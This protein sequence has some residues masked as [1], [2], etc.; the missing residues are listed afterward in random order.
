VN[1]V[2]HTR[3]CIHAS[4]LKISVSITCE[5]GVHAL[6]RPIIQGRVLASPK[7][8][9][10]HLVLARCVLKKSDAPKKFD[11]VFRTGCVRGTVCGEEQ[12]IQLVVTAHAE[13][14]PRGAH[15]G[16]V[17]LQQSRGGW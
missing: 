3:R 13:I 1:H 17:W 16:D 4:V 15:H 2:L 11:G 8:W 10:I 5:Q 12:Q 7:V 14:L 9:G 6:V